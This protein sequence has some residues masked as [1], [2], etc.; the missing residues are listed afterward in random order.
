MSAN[1]SKLLGV[2]YESLVEANVYKSPSKVV[3]TDNGGRTY[4]IVDRSDFDRRLAPLGYEN[5]DHA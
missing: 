3:V 4:F 1:L 2:R 5:V